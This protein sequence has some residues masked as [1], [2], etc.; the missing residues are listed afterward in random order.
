MIKTLERTRNKQRKELFGR[1]DEV[2]ERRES[3]IEHLET[4]LNQKTEVEDLFV[5]AWEIQ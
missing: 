2:D 4:K 5:I 1:Q 3:L